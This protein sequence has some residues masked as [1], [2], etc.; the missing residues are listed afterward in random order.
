MNGM[1]AIAAALSLAVAAA[2]QA[3]LGPADDGREVRLPSPTFDV[4]LPTNAGTG[5]HWE[6]DGA[7]SRG[8]R[9]VERGAGRGPLHAPGV[10]GYPSATRFILHTTARTGEVRIL[11][12]PPGV[13]R[14]AERVWRVRFQRTP[15]LSVPPQ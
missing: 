9:L 15:A 11:L 7:G 13:G 6:F 12:V 2:V 10:V 14:G 8:V 4:I 3:D 1:A 5:Y